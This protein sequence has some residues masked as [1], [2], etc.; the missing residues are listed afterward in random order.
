MWTHIARCIKFELVY[1]YTCGQLSVFLDNS[2]RICPIK[3][4][5]DMLYHMDKTVFQ[6]FVP[7]PLR[8]EYTFWFWLV[9]TSCHAVTQKVWILIIIIR[10]SLNVSHSYKNDMRKFMADATNILTEP[11]SSMSW[12]INQLL[13][14]AYSEPC[15]ISKLELLVKIIN[16]FQHGT[17][18]RPGITCKKILL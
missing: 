3:L 9:K 16:D 12:R 17:I 8:D 11:K 18:I 10:F 13:P 5:V 2:G 7:A 1:L 6:I 4:K 14:E 15:Q